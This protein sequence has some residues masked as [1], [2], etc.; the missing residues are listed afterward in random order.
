MARSDSRSYSL[1][2]YD[3]THFFKVCELNLG[4]IEFYKKLKNRCEDF[5]NEKTKRKYSE[6]VS[7]IKKIDAYE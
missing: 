1:S 2:K 7:S 3:L 6:K 4:D 5:L